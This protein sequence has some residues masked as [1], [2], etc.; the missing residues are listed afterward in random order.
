M[1]DQFTQ[2]V[3][4]DMVSRICHSVMLVGSISWVNR[5]H[6]EHKVGWSGYHWN[7]NIRR[8]D[9]LVSVCLDSLH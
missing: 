9:L 7:L 8:S 2:V 5:S 6:I 4:D 3:E 1:E